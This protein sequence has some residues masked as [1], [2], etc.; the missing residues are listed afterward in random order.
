MLKK[1]I[2]MIC[3]IFQIVKKRIYSIPPKD[4]LYF[5]L[6]FYGFSTISIFTFLLT[7]TYCSYFL[8][9]NDISI[10]RLALA[11]IV[12]IGIIREVLSIFQKISPAFK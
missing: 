12:Y 8:G 7:D 6:Q 3:K 11:F 9:T 2:K 5:R 4:L 10:V 1:I